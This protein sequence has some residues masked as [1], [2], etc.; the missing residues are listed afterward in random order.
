MG[1]ILKIQEMAARANVDEAQTVPFIIDAF[2]ETVHLVLPSCIRLYSFRFST[3]GEIWIRTCIVDIQN[4]IQN[5]Y[6]DLS[7]ITPG[8]HSYEMK[9]RFILP[10]WLFYSYRREVDRIVQDLLHCG[11]MRPSNSSFAFHNVLI[12]KKY[13]E[14][15]M[16]VDY[17]PLNK[18]TL[19]DS[20]SLP[21]IDD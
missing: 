9:I 10:I 21:I 11:Y 2:H 4:L 12:P 19:Q 16:C 8:N 6:F 18:V 15:R 13:G 17:R 20:Y 7:N 3:C 5:D 14:K 1:Y